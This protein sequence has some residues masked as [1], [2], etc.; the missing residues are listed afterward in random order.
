MSAVKCFFSICSQW[1]QWVTVI[2]STW[3]SCSDSSVFLLA[4]KC[5]TQDLNLLMLL[6]PIC[7]SCLCPLAMG[8][9]CHIWERLLWNSRHL[10]QDLVSFCLWFYCYPEKALWSFGASVF[11]MLYP[12]QEG[13]RNLR[14]PCLLVLGVRFGG[15]SFSMQMSL[16]DLNRSAL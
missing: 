13:T 9:R 8:W 14:P 7:S 11:V 5:T 2:P 15:F 10:H 3:A 4:Q 12:C 1:I 6:L 16:L